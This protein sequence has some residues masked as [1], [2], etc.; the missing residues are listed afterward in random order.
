[1]RVA[2][3]NVNSVRARIERIVPWLEESAPDVVLLQETKADD[4]QFPSA[5]LAALGY[6][7]AHYG[8]GRWNG[9]AILSRVGLRAVERGLADGEARMISALCGPLRATSC[10]VPNGRALD[11]P[12]FAA[13]LRW[14]DALR[15]RREDRDR[16]VP[17]VIGGDF[18][19]APADLDCYDPASFVGATHVSGAERAALDALEAT[20]L[21]DAWRHLHPH[22]PG[23]TWWDYRAGAFHLD[24]GLRIDLLLVEDSLVPALEAAT[25]D[26]EA[27]RG[28]KPSDHA[29]VWIDLALESDTHRVEVDV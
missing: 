5:T 29:P 8:Q 20:G 4:G 9:V 7:S 12:H 3:W 10:Y 13:K 1:M 27:R 15:D 22:E 25:V 21:T 16:G 28:P 6:E 2:T 18:N 23:Y 14:L 11:D 17:E 19:V 26:R 24:H